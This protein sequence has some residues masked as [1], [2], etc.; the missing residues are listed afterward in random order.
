MMDL[1]IKQ[2]KQIEQKKRGNKMIYLHRD[3]QQS[4]IDYTRDDCSHFSA[5]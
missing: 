1:D 4:I 2:K 3:S 5:D